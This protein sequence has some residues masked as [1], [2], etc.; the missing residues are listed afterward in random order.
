MEAGAGFTETKRYA[1]LQE[2][3]PYQEATLHI[4]DAVDDSLNAV[5]LPVVGYGGE[6]D[7]QLQ[8]STNIREQLTREGF[9]FRHE[10]LNWFGA[11]LQS[12][13]LVG[14][15]TAH[16]FHPESKKTSD[17]FIERAVANGRKERPEHI[18]FITYTPRYNTAFWIHVDALDRQ[19][20]RAEIDA[21]HTAGATT[22]STKNVAR[23]E[24]G[25]PGK[26]IVDGKSFRAGPLALAKVH[27]AWSASGKEGL[28]K[29]HGLQGPIDDA[30]MEAFVCVRPTGKPMSPAAGEYARRTLDNFSKDFSKFFRGDVPVKDDSALS[31]SDI[32][33]R[34]LVLFGDPGSNSVIARVLSRLPLRWTADTVTLAGKK[35]STAEHVPALIY[36]NPLNPSRYVVINSGHTFGEADLKGT[37]ALLYPRRGD[38]AVMKVADGSTALAGL[39]DEAWHVE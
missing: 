27:G 1:K 19:Y 24:V 23:I 5:N 35:F 33:Q 21:R 8:G 11:D 20:E 28:R 15:Q 29:R 13:F 9:H 18:R 34:N 12:I 10:G 32:A 16:K 2:I 30:F 38:Y 6:I 17:E 25:V 39:F 31:E 36:P 22:I 7:P 26:V 4:Y 14:P 37:N 3:P